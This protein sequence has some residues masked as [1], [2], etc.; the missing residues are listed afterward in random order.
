VALT[1]KQKGSIEAICAYGFK[2]PPK[3]TSIKA[4]EDEFKHYT[5]A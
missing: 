2:R 3:M 5:N 1:K 4:A